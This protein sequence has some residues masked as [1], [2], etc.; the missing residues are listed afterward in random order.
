MSPPS[1]TS[2]RRFPIGLA[3]SGGG[4]RAMAFHLG[5]LRALHDLGVLNKVGVLSTIS[6]GSVIGAYYAYT[7]KKS[8]DDFESD[9]RRC[10]Q[11]GFHGMIGLELLK[12]HNLLLS[13]LSFVAAQTQ[14]ALTLIS[15]GKVQPFIPRFSSRTDMFQKVLERELFP[16]LVMSSTRR[17]NLKVVIGACELRHG[18]AFRF[19]DGLS[20]GW[21]HG[22]MVAGDVPLAFAVAASAAYVRLSLHRIPAALKE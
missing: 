21:R 10:L 15:R 11:V 22:K 13:S 5:C 8:F 17:P 20:G 7:P 12:P 19:S 9:I 18:E 4:S 16:G 6:G 1:A 3:L 14:E 2:E